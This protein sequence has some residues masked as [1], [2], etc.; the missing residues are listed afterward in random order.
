MIV[1]FTVKNFRSI[2]E[3]TFDLRTSNKV[4][5]LPD[6]IFSINRDSLV[7]SC[8]IYGRNASGKSNILK[9]LNDLTVMIRL[10]SNFKHGE[11]IV[12]YEPFKFDTNLQKK[13]CIFEIVFITIEKIK[14]EYKFSFDSNKIIS[15]SLFYFPKNKAVKLF[16]REINNIS[17]GDHYKGSKKEIEKDLL[18]NQLFLSKSSNR[19]IPLL[20]EAYLYFVKNLQTFTYHDS[21]TEKIINRNL[22]QTI[23]NDESKKLKKNLIN[24]LKSADIN[25][26]DFEVNKISKASISDEIP[27]D[28]RE[29]VSSMIENNPYRIETYHKLFNTEKEIGIEKIK[30]ESESLGTQRLLSIGSLVILSLIVGGTIVIDELDKSLHPILTRALI[31]LFH[32]KKNNPNNAQL[33]IA[34][35]DS[36]LLDNELFRRDQIYFTE[37]NYTGKTE[38]YRLSDIKG[39]RNNIPY[40]KWYLSGRFDAIPVLDDFEIEF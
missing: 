22:Y 35:H 33:I 34:S 27:N 15:E 40:D 30:F 23:F 1:E 26:L 21:D 32:S 25:I 9:A 38:L 7:S 29:K 31:K 36:S 8:I 13:P 3:E 11:E 6:N 28:I 16:D 20:K 17:Y 5:E 18:E 4:K 14:F 12:Y 10:S 37:K 19:N 2:E 39:V 24:L